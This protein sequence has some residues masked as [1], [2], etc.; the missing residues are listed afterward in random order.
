MSN[1]FWDEVNSL[2]TNAP[3][4][5]LEYRLYYDEV[6]KIHARSATESLPY[7][8]YLVVTPEE[9]D[10]YLDYIVMDGQLKTIDRTPS[11]N[12][13]KLK[14]SDRG[15]KVVRGHMGLILEP[16]EEY[17]DIEYYEYKNC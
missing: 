6:G 3:I 7:E 16:N 5:A 17:N 15:I 2:I 8:Q 13:F 4:Q 11:F 9:Y 12:E 10:S 14:K 1:E